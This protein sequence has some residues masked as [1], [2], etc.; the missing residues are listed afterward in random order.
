MKILIT[1][2][3]PFGGSDRNSAHMAM[4]MLPEDYTKHTIIKRT[5]P[6]V[7]RKSIEQLK[8]MIDEVVPDAVICL[9]QAAAERSL[10][11]E[12]IAVNL[13]DAKTKDNEGN[14][15]I[16]VTIAEGCQDAYFATL[17][18]RAMMEECIKQE[19]PAHI[20]YTAGNYVCNHVMYGLLNYIK[21]KNI[22]GGFIH[23]PSAPAQVAGSGN[24]PSMNSGDAAKGILA[25]I[26]IL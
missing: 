14:A 13:D 16:D 20:S 23:I 21:G 6:V 5:L 9:G 19:I 11:I 26:D 7:Y 18:T 4:D 2:F 17:P 3:E 25:M 24:H 22:M 10:R 8:S 15:H 1:A 12:R